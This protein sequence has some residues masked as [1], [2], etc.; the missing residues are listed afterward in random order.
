MKIDLLELF[1]VPTELD[2]KSV[3]ALVKAIN[4]NHIKDF[5]Y[6]KFKTSVENLEEIQADENTRF[7]TTFM[8]AQTLG[9]SKEHL[10]DTARHY[11]NVLN[12]EKEKFTSALQ[13]KMNEAIEGKKEE[14]KTIDQ[15]INQKKRKVEQ[16]LKEIK[17]LEKR[18]GSID[19]EVEKAKTRIRST[20]D[21]F[22]NAIEHFERT[23]SED[24]EK[25]TTIL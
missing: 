19:S 9:I 2:Q 14:A 7:K 23:I 15:E 3:N 10:L 11:Q 20:R 12:K 6:L 17:A 22:V 18:A 1:G 13:N 4:A 21:K 16:L 5:D 24:I 25:M 8:T